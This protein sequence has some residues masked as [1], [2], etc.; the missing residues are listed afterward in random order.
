MNFHKNVFARMGYEK[1]ADQIQRL[2][3]EGHRKDVVDC[4]TDD[5]VRDISL[6]GSPEQIRDDLAQWEEA[7]VTHLV[8]GCRDVDEVR[9]LAD[10]ILDR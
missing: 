8:M 5:M 2:F 3:L 6:I 9:R 1:E 7:G 10:V 4:V